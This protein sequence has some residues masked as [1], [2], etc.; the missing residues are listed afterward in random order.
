MRLPTT[1]GDS[2][3]LRRA[4]LAV[5]LA[6]GAASISACST[7]R[8]TFGGYERGPDGISRAQHRL[9][10]ALAR[11]DFRVALGWHEDDEL[12][13][14]LTRATSAY[15]ASQFLRAGTL[16]DS[17][18]LVADDRITASVSRDALALVTND[19]ARRYQPRPTE[20]LFIAYYGMLSYVQLERWEDAA[21][22]ARRMVSLLAQRDADRDAEERP[23]HA[24]LES[25]AGAV[26]E[27]AG[28]A[29]EAQVAYRAAHQMLAVAPERAGRLAAGD[30]EVLVVLERGFVAHR[31][32][33]QLNVL[34]GEDDDDSL[35]RRGDRR[36][37]PSVRL[38][39]RLGNVDASRRGPAEPSTEVTYAGDS[40]RGGRKPKDRDDDP[41][42]L[43][44]SFP[45]LHRSGRP[46]GDAVRLS[47]DVP[48]GEPTRLVSVIDD[49][50]I[51]DERR[52][53]VAMLA[54]A[55]ARASAKYVVTKAV[56]DKK[57]ETAGKLANLG[58]SLLERADVRS[59]HL[60]PQEVQLL[61]MALPAGTRSLRLEVAD[62]AGTRVVELGSVTVRVGQ[63]TIV[64]H[65]LWRDPAAVPLIAAR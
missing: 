49:A 6:I 13:R 3:S 51:V 57:G 48:A 20:R 34:L 31:V 61:R 52:D 55:V 40:A 30:G 21:V 27:R 29:G 25:L 22:E 32:T 46:W 39:E 5:A 26:L 44:V 2:R 28:R 14:A 59:W 33:E 47:A 11:G 19:N 43:A 54:R 24:A 60:L 12:L 65:R 18:A 63:V 42:W 56:K 36:E 15:Y 7:I 23:L 50:A 9:R 8:A 64:P 62:G 53:R 16:L 17:A 4:A 37:R 45:V 10:E 1:A 38:A 35:S 41:Y 58:A